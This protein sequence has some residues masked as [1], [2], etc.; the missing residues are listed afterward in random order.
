MNKIILVSCFM[1]LGIC[2]SVTNA[3]G[4]A[5]LLVLIFGEK[6]ASET[7]NFSIVTGLNISNVSAQKDSKSLKGLNFGLGINMKLSDKWFFKPEFRPLSPKGFQSNATLKTSTGIDASFTNVNAT[8]TLNYIDVPLMI[9]YQAFK[10]GQIGLGPQVSFL[11]NAKEKFFGT[12]D[13][14][15]EQ[16]LKS[17][18]NK[19]DFG[20]NAAFT[21]L[22]STKRG[23]KGMNVQ[24]RY[25]KGLSS[26]YTIGGTNNNNVLSFNFEFP[27]LSD[28]VAEKNLQLNK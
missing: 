7:F 21:Y 25:Y 11:T 9:H 14:T 8:R 6:A 19:T 10:R 13:A 23:G 17:Q 20:I 5:A 22:L 15:Y 27:F 28:Q 18:L 4:Q 1:L 3:K 2:A 26:V 16:D 24:L 12:N